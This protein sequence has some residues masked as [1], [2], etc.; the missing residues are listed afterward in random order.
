MTSYQKRTLLEQQIEALNILIQ[1]MSQL[2]DAAIEQAM[3]A[4]LQRD[5][6]L[7]EQVIAQDTAVNALRHQ[8]EQLTLKSIATQQPMAGDLRAILSAVYVALDLERIGDHAANV[9]R[10]VL[11]L[12]AEEAIDSYYG[13]PGMALHA[14]EMVRLSVNAFLTHDQKL[15][16]EV[17]QADDQVDARYADLIQATLRDMKTDATIQRATMLLL[18]GQ[19]LERIGDRATNIAE[20]AV[21]VV[22]GVMEEV[23]SEPDF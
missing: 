6:P 7:A 16:Q 18:V 9:A 14:R 8:V 1:Q 13:L 12:A 5:S 10:L 19:N 23:P 22:S 17:M 20:R 2:A 15:A 21:F 3:A 4:L 11:R